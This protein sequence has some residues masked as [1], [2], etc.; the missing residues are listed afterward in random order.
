MS[1]RGS[2]APDSLKDDLLAEIDAWLKAEP[3]G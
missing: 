3:E 1:V 2:R